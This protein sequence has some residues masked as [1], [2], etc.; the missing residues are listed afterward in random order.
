MSCF[1]A[2]ELAEMDAADTMREIEAGA[3]L[4]QA[5]WSQLRR[6][7]MAR[8]GIAAGPYT[9]HWLPGQTY[10]VRGLAPDVMAADLRDEGWGSWE[11]AED[12]LVEL[13]R[14]FEAHKAAQAARRRTPAPAT[15]PAVETVAATGAATTTPIT[16]ETIDA[17][18]TAPRMPR[19]RNGRRAAALGAG[20][21]HRRADLSV[22]V[23]ELRAPLGRRRRPG[24]A[25]AGRLRRLPAHLTPAMR[26]TQQ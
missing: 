21:G 10:R 18:S 8:G 16:T 17:S 5:T 6:E 11:T 3:T 23:A 14:M 4:R 9:R 26:L 12:F 20:P 7:I 25:P 19:L 13:T 2:E 22:Y 24:R 1:S 15:M